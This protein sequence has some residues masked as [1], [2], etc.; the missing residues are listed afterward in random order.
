MSLEKVKI[1][2]LENVKIREV[3]YGKLNDCSGEVC[4]EIPSIGEAKDAKNIQKTKLVTKTKESIKPLESEILSRNLLNTAELD[5][6]KSFLL[7]A[8][9]L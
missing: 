1:Q 8:R 2:E 4:V 6:K 9:K 7:V 5:Y 3:K